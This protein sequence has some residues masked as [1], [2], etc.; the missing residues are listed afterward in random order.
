MVGNNSGA[1]LAVPVKPMLLQ[2]RRRSVAHIVSINSIVER[3][4]ESGAGGGERKREREKERAL[5]RCGIC[6]YVHVV[7]VCICR[8]TAA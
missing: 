6:Y 4:K 3:D 8:C 2:C 5:A 1:G 7:E